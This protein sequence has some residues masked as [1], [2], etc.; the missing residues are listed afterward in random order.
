M[1]PKVGLL[2]G[3]DCRSKAVLALFGLSSMI[4]HTHGFAMLW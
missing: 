4:M 3:P 1:L 2:D